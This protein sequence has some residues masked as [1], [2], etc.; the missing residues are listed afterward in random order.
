MQ[1]LCSHCQYSGELAPS[2]SGAVVCPG[3]GSSLHSESASTAGW[4]PADERRRFG[5][6]E[7]REAVGTGAFGTVYEAHDTELVRIVAIKVPRSDRLTGTQGETERFLREARS[8]AQ[9]RHPSI[10]SIHDVFLA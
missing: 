4:T 9:F 5:R 10:V 6:F 3:S 7:L 8:V 2:A 1:V